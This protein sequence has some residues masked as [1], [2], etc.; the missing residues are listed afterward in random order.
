MCAAKP[1]PRFF[2]GSDGVIRLLIAPNTNVILLSAL[3]FPV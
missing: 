3:P 2:C 1:V